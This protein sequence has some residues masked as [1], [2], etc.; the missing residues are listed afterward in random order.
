[1]TINEFEDYIKSFN[2]VPGEYTYEEQMLIG[3]KMKELPVNMRNW[4]NLYVTL[5]I[6]DCSAN[7][8]RQRVEKFVHSDNPE[9]VQGI[10]YKESYVAQQK[11]R[12]WY[13]AYRR[14]IRE[15]TRIENFKDEILH[16]ANKFKDLPQIVF[17]DIRDERDRE[18][19]LVLSDLH[20]GAEC[21]N[22]Y[23]K[24]NLKIAQS[25]VSQLVS[26]VINYCKL[27]NV[28]TLNIL[29]LG[30]MIQGIIHTNA[31]IEQQMDVAE[32]VMKAG[33]TLAEA[34]NELQKA[35][36]IVTYRSVFDNHSRAI[37]NKEE[38]IEKEQFSRVIDWFIEERLKNSQVKF[39]KDNIDGGIGKFKLLN[40]KV[41]VFAHG[42]QDNINSSWQ[43]FI[44]L[45]KNW[46]DYIILAHYHN[47]KEKTY[48]GSTVFVN[49]SI[50][51]VEN[52]AFGRRLFSQPS[53]KLLIFN[54]DD[55]DIQDININ[56]K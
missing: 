54:P 5:G 4:N 9:Y 11:V 2:K 26:K 37:A 42:H 19:I 7:A 18:A 43:N 10:M 51:G 3:A 38:H 8:Y 17:E 33:E 12:D 31:R 15:E 45:T 44:G 13:N 20:I 29:N 55:S 36:P 25:R 1:M 53:Q 56:L 35:A 49:G 22:Y 6:T 32:Q 41:V 34:I 48:N 14:D 52:Y 40:N 30:D 46:V 23:N 21:D 39:I 27:N 50:V 24:Y 47:P 16:A 28:K